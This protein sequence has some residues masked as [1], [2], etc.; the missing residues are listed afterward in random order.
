MSVRLL[1]LAAV[2]CLVAACGL[3]LASIRN[4]PVE[5][6]GNP[7]VWSVGFCV[8]TW[9]FALTTVAG[10]VQT[11]RARRWEVRLWVRRH[12]LLV[13]VGNVVVLAYL[14]YWGI[15]GLRFWA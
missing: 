8:L 6:L 5:R 15:I 11:L 10:L 4:N 2:I 14:A 7:T 13:S 12:A 3:L 1:P 9:L